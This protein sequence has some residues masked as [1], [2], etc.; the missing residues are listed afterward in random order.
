ML[1]EG[2]VLKERYKIDSLIKS[3]GMGSIYKA[4][5]MRL[6]CV[7]A[8]KELIPSYEQSENIEWFEREAKILASLSHPGLTKVCD[9]FTYNC[10]YYI[11]MDFIEGHDLLSLLEKEGKPG[12]SEEKVI[13][14]SVEIL[15]ILDYLHSQPPPVLYRDMKPANIMLN[16]EGRIILIDFG[17]A[18]VLNNIQTQTVI[19]TEGYAPPEQFRG[20]AEV[21]SDLY[22][23]GATIHHLLSGIE[24][25]PFKFE[26]IS[27]IS[28]EL[29]RI[30]L[31][32]L[33]D[34]Q[35]ERFPSAKRM[36]KELTLMKKEKIS[37]PS[38]P[39]QGTWKKQFTDTEA[40]LRDIHFVDKNCGW[41]AGYSGLF[42]GIILNTVNGG[43]S[44]K[45]RKM[46]GLASIYFVNPFE[47]WAVGGGLT[48][49]I[50]LHST[51]GGTKWEK[52]RAGLFIP[53]LNKI[54]FINF[55]K[56][57]IA[58]DKG[59]ILHTEDGGIKWEKQK[60]H[61]SLELYSIYFVNSDTGWITGQGGLILHTK[62]SGENWIKQ[63]SN[64]SALL[65][66]VYFIDEKNGF[67]AGDMG[68][69]LYTE[70]GG[71]KWEKKELNIP[72]NFNGIYF[73]EQNGFISGEKGIIL[74]TEDRGEN[75]QKL[76]G[77]TSSNLFGIYFADSKNGWIAG[78]KGTILKYL[79]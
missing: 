63:K 23:L 6:N 40:L 33:N 64:T 75:W 67:T 42:D 24:P 31:K 22:S 30:I 57:W 2:T 66:S 16:K 7:C 74:H 52:K 28:P 1:T 51:D 54:Y 3:G 53:L 27:F 25:V 35:E 68:T 18:R 19:G 26:K 44:W 71:E 32:S 73:T 48:E 11:V 5:D 45:G 72:L 55:T 59:F 12:L 10:M 70:D 46:A 4:F 58:G 78:E 39:L 69:L 60:S 29:N 77:I 49:G 76:T 9:Y 38:S 41:A 61:T 14:W 21:R 62:D 47:G 43:K 36:L 17:I 34:N 13:S 65:R 8:V 37:S 56:G 20:R 50:I 15:K 79:Y